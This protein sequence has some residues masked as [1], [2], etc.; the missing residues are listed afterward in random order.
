MENTLNGQYQKL[1]KP[2]QARLMSYCQALL[3][4]QE[5]DDNE[6]S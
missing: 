6:Q 3:D 5:D 2:N 4:S 1:T